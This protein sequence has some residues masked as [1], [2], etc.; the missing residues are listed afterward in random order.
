MLPEPGD[1]FAVM[2]HYVRPLENSEL[3]YLEI[4][5][6]KTQ[7]DILQAKYGL[8]NRTQWEEFR[9]TGRKPIG[10]LLTFDDGLK[11]HFE[12]VL[13]YLFDRNI[14][15]I[16]YICTNPLNNLTLPV[17][18]MHYLLSN[19]K[20]FDIWHDF[21]AG[22]LP[23]DFNKVFDDKSELAYVH[24]DHT[25]P[26]KE[27]KKLINYASEDIGQK[28]LL[29]DIFAKKTNLTQSDFIE[30]WYMSESEILEIA[31]KGFE[32][33]SHTCSHRL[34]SRLN[35]VEIDHELYSSRHILGEVSKTEIKSFC[36][37]YGR[38]YS[39]NQNILNRIAQ[40]GY[41]ESFDVNPQPI[42][43]RFLEKKYRF[44]LPRYDCKLFL[45]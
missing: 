35:D 15:A 24:R 16:F 3:R 45:N 14:F 9:A 1:F 21:I 26:E 44:R 43:D 39:Y 42:K 29:V 13:P 10:A 37:P 11:D 40:S 17:H 6:F 32:I 25:Q 22:G 5:Q 36:L 23:K 34:M 2:F 7:I 12:F 38:P 8:I 41:A 31:S 33:G 19:H 30:S 28:D 18:L 27:L 4:E 20:A